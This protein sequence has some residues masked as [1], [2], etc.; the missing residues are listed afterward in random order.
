[1]RASRFN[2]A[3]WY[4]RHEWESIYQALYSK[5]PQEQS[6]GLRGVAVWRS[7]L[8][9]RLPG[10][11]EATAALVRAQMC[12]AQAR[13]SD[14]DLARI[15]GEELSSL[16]SVGV[17]RF[18][19]DILEP[20]CHR[21]QINVK[22]IGLQMGVPDWIV[23]LRNTLAHA[24]TGPS[25]DVLRS[26]AILLLQWLSVHY[27]ES[28]RHRLE[29]GSL[30]VPTPDDSTAD[31]LEITSRVQETLRKL[32]G[33]ASQV[34]RF[35]KNKMAVIKRKGRLIL[36]DI[37]SEAEAHSDIV[38]DVLLTTEF[39]LP[40]ESSLRTL[41]PRT[42]VDIP[43][44]SDN[45][46]LSVPQVLKQAWG[47]VLATLGVH[48]QRLAERLLQFESTSPLQHFLAAAWLSHLLNGSQPLFF[49]LEDSASDEQ[50]PPRAHLNVAKLLRVAMN[51]PNDYTARI[52]MML[53]R[54]MTPALSERQLYQLVAL[55]A[56]QT[57]ALADDHDESEADDEPYTVEDFQGCNDSEQGSDLS[58]KEELT[59][60]LPLR[61][62]DWESTP[63]GM[64]PGFCGNNLNL[65]LQFKELKPLGT[66][67]S[68]N[69]TTRENDQDVDASLVD[70]EEMEQQVEQQVLDCV[71]RNIR[72]FVM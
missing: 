23:D 8:H 54:E 36:K 40:D 22:E 2:V 1:M 44:A 55:A 63:I 33:V 4:D 42:V 5:S 62:M 24:A 16:Y 69:E 52:L 53:A 58:A 15:S 47:P 61:P 27:W 50:L 57:G 17:V 14:P 43:G 60:T 66:Q 20:L 46:P 56:I 6:T 39:L 68:G 51:H 11:I 67:G 35:W 64:L 21:R 41:W 72:L 38:I 34:R 48:V 45:S 49:T 10:A 3:P 25:L 26:A 29:D 12:D 71:S 31:L 59:W 28:E 19:G 13:I 70:S 37:A 7:R 65:E 18:V 9:S 30:L 32:G